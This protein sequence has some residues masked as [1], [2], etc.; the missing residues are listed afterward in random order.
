[1]KCALCRKEAELEVSHIIPKFVFRTLKKNSPTG[2]MRLTSEPNRKVQDGDKQRLLCGECEDLFNQ[3]ETTFANTIYHEFQAGTL[4]EFEYSTWLNRFIISVNW[5][6][7]YLDIVGFVSE[8]NLEPY[9]LEVLIQAEKVMREYLLGERFDTGSIENHIFFFNPIKDASEQFVNMDLHTVIG[10]SVFGYTFISD[11][12]DSYYV[13]LNLQGLIVVSI[14]NPAAMEEWE[15]TLVE[16]NGSFILST[17]QIIT[18][19]LFSE[20]QYL[21]DQRK[22]AMEKMTEN[23]RRKIIESV[24]KNLERFQNSKAFQRAQHDHRL[25]DR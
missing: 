20:F 2:N 1:M 4:T 3:D 15:N 21:A 23:Q 13:F 7:L 11:D 18:S 12:Y 16:D 25:K 8:G 6:N 5:R 10:G 22:Q 24:E 14:I 9:K 19:P 17:P